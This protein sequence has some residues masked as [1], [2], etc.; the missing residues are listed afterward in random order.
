VEIF[1]ERFK[2][3]KAQKNLTYPQIGE[4]LGLQPRT[5][6]LYASG[7]AKPDYHGLIMLA[8]YFDV[9][10]DYLVGRSDVPERR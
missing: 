5:I 1:C 3:L 9:S 4:Y 7:G 8:D 10:I 6:K 2:E